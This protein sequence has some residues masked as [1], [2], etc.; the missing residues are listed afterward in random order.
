MSENSQPKPYVVF[1][2]LSEAEGNE[3]FKKHFLHPVLEGLPP[4]SVPKPC[5]LCRRIQGS[6]S[7]ALRF[8]NRG[9]PEVEQLFRPL[10][11]TEVRIPGF[12]ETP[13]FHLCTECCLLM[14]YFA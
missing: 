10:T 7:I 13:V 4:D 8:P 2:G 6:T 1:T 14:T 9:K 12:T 3:I 11:F 5:Y